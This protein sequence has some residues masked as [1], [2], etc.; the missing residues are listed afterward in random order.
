ML[1]SLH[2]WWALSPAAAYRSYIPD[3]LDISILL[4]EK[5]IILDVVLIFFLYLL[6]LEYWLSGD[7]VP[8]NIDGGS[9]LTYNWVYRHTV[10]KEYTNMSFLFEVNFCRKG[11]LQLGLKNK[12]VR[13][14]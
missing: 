2:Q 1:G 9:E 13:L 7:F 4:N 10:E 14:A 3:S 5:L 8:N 6:Q 11:L 12:S